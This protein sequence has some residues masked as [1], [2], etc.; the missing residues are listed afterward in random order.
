MA[1]LIVAVLSWCASLVITLLQ[2]YRVTKK[3]ANL[4]FSAELNT[5]SLI[6]TVKNNQ[7]IQL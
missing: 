3:D 7:V 2:H 6:F 4:V 5:C 1:R